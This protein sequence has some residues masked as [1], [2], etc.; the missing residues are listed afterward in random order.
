MSV[1]IARSEIIDWWSNARAEVYTECREVEA[2][3]HVRVC[4]DVEKLGIK[5][6]LK[7]RSAEIANIRL[8]TKSDLNMLGKRLERQLEASVLQSIRVTEGALDEQVVGAADIAGLVAGGAAAAGAIGLAAS[9]T[10]LATTTAAT[11]LFIFGGASVVSWP[12][13]AAVGGTALTL[14]AISPTAIRWTKGR[15]K[16]RYVN[17]MQAHVSRLLIEDAHDHDPESI[18]GKFLTHLDMLK[19]K[20]L[21]Q[22]QWL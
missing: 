16:A 22:L 6:I 13:V 4:E 18:C 3:L 2:K 11:Y 9:A 19:D 10:T 14:S 12:V 20:R 7:P 17:R 1:E 8:R 5:E 15:I 21:E